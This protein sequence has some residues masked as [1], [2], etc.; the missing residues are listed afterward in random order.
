MKKL[1]KIT[2]LFVLALFSCSFSFSQIVVSEKLADPANKIVQKL[3]KRSQVWIAGEWTVENSQYVW[4]Q[5]YWTNK[6]PGYVFIAGYWE[7][8]KGGW[9]WVPGT[10]KQISM[11][12]WNALYA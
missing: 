6:R 9:A 3:T 1:Q 7:K 10:W 2:V 8:R 4:T 12:N 5:G 11:K